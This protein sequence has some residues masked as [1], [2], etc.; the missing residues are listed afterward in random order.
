MP[1]IVKIEYRT[2][3]L[4]CKIEYNIDPYCP[5]DRMTPPTEATAEIISVEFHGMELVK[6]LPPDVISD[7]KQ[8]IL[9]TYC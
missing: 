2:L 1:K 8:E 5:G 4:D 6:Y 7:L 9:E 3:E